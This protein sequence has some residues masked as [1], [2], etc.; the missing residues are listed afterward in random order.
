MSMLSSEKNYYELLGVSFDAPLAA[1]KEAYRE[2]ARVY[3]PDSNFYDEILTEEQSR[4]AVE[5]FQRITEAYH[6][7]SDPERRAKYDDILP[8]NL[9]DWNTEEFDLFTQTS[10]KMEIYTLRRQA[11]GQTVFGRALDPSMLSAELEDQESPPRLRLKKSS[12]FNTIF[13]FGAALTIPI[14][15]I[16]LYRMFFTS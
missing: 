16:I 3:H 9:N 7:L 1:I 11:N 5:A 12:L 8:K 10:E 6:T 13:I 4:Q 15:A 14:A 2:I